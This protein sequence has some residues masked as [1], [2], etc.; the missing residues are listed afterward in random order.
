M[1]AYHALFLVLLVGTTAFFTVLSALNVRHGRRALERKSDWVAERLDLE[2][3]DRIIDYQR[4]T[5]IRSQG[6]TWAILAL[7]LAVLYS[8]ALATAVEWLEG[9]GYG[10]IAT[11]TAFFVAAVVGLRLVSVPFDA[12]ETFVIEERFDFN[13]ASPGLFVTD[14]LLGT[15]L[16][17]VF[18]AVLAA[19]VLWVVARLPT[20]WPLAATALFAAVSLAM[21]VLYPRVIAPLFNDFEPVDAGDLR[22]AVERVFERAGFTCDDVYVMDAS[23]RSSHSNAYFVGFGRTKRVVLFDT[24]LDRMGLAEI[25]AVLAHELVHWKKRHVW[26]GFAAGLVRI[27]AM[28]AV[29][30]YL[31]EAPWLSELFALPEI[32]YVGLAMGALWLQPLAKFTSPLE[33]RL[34]LAHEREADAFATAVM[35]DGEPLVDALCRLTSENLANPFPHPLYATFHYTHP[36]IPDRIRYIRQVSASE[37]ASE[38]PPPG[39]SGAD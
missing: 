37:D 20:Y 33:N 9:L 19:A 10:P 31:L 22:T 36:P 30:W 17:A 12:Y 4:A 2:D 25:E 27:G 39:A 26:K 24:L 28:L 11:G 35:G 16:A 1:L 15:V 21:L 29:L 14:F 32:T 23:K 18:T 7:V 34:S 5:T 38:T 8:G 13:E 3:T 6:Q